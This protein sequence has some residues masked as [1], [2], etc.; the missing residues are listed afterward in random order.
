[1]HRPLA[2]RQLF[3]LMCR[4]LRGLGPCNLLYIYIYIYLFFYFFIFFS[5]SSAKPKHRQYLNF[6]SVWPTHKPSHM[7]R[8]CVHLDYAICVHFV[9]TWPTQRASN[10]LAHANFHLL[11]SFLLHYIEI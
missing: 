9:W 8:L 5:L 10:S 1:M 4:L 11:P 6:A 7:C 2:P 3:F